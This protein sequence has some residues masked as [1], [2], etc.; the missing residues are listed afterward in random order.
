MG[1]KPE[2]AGTNSDN[3]GE[4][5]EPK[6]EPKWEV[7]KEVQSSL[8]RAK[9]NL[10]E[11]KPRVVTI[12]SASRIEI[13]LEQ[14]LKAFLKTDPAE[15]DSLLDGRGALSTFSPKIHLA[16]R[17]SLVDDGLA[18]TLH[19]IRK[20][21]NSFAH[22]MSPGNFE[23]SPHADRLQEIY[24]PIRDENLKPWELLDESADTGLKRFRMAAILTIGILEFQQRHT[25]TFDPGVEEV[26]FDAYTE[27]RG[28]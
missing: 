26:G 18:H 27:G 8:N 4:A 9:E 28:F 20:T 23:E 14:C 21:R 17:L 3:E 24:Q 25:R 6:E 22:E 12:A 11:E 7:K 16:N 15:S 10:E 19:M 1:A 13:L 5:N 2:P